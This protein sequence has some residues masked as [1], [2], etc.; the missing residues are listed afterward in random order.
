MNIVAGFHSFIFDL[1]VE[2]PRSRRKNLGT[3]DRHRETSATR[4][5]K[6]L[7]ARYDDDVTNER[8]VRRCCRRH[9]A[10]MDATGRIALE[11]AI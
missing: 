8:D 9:C 6:E 4:G 5:V 3:S 7:S 2:S 1:D 11:G 10:R